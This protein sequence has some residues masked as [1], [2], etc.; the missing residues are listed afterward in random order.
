MLSIS[1]P[2]RSFQEDRRISA[3]EGAMASGWGVESLGS[4]LLFRDIYGGEESVGVHSDGVTYLAESK[5]RTGLGGRHLMP[6]FQLF[7]ISSQVVSSAL[8][9]LRL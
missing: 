6:S 8:L 3:A 5:A 1:K 4:A 9:V 2:K 7:P